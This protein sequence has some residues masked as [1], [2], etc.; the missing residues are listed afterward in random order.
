MDHSKVFFLVA[1][2]ESTFPVDMT[3]IQQA[4]VNEIQSYFPNNPV[5]WVGLNQVREGLFQKAEQAKKDFPGAVIVT[6]SS[7]YFPTANLEIRANR[8]VDTHKQALGLGPRPKAPSMKKQVE[9]VMTKAGHA[10]IVTIDDT[11]FQGHTLELL[12][13]EGLRIDA[14]VEYFT[15]LPTKQR[16]ESEGHPVYTVVALDDYL[17][18]MPIHDFLPPLPLCGKVV[19]VKGPE[20]YVPKL[21]NNVSFSV[22]YLLPWLTPEEL[23]KW[24]SIPEAH[25]KEF[26]LFALDQSIEVMERLWGQGFSTLEYAVEYQPMRMSVPFLPGHMPSMN[27]GITVILREYRHLVE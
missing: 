5:Q 26:S 4:F 3:D 8:L 12:Q 17:D 24:A 7:L 6:L 10:P 14:S 13:A 18:V 20:G 23:S 27:A 9:R 1:G 21:V 15:S 22:P 25:A 11:L 16:L 19:G 2:S